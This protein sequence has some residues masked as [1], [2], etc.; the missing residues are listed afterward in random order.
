MKEFLTLF[1][2]TDLCCVRKVIKMRLKLKFDRFYIVEMSNF[3]F[4][5]LLDAALP[6]NFYQ[7]QYNYCSW[8]PLLPNQQKIIQQNRQNRQNQQKIQSQ[9]TIFINKNL[10]I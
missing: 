2:I 10:L 5:Q 3:N 4:N 8:F 7:Y 6:Y 9:L 1:S